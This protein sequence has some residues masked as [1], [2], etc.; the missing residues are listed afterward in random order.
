MRPR[1]KTFLGTLVLILAAAVLAVGLA[2]TLTGDRRATK[3]DHRDQ[4]GYIRDEI[5]NLRK[6]L[7]E[8]TDR[9]REEGKTDAQIE[10]M[11]AKFQ[12]EFD[13]LQGEIDKLTNEKA[14]NGNP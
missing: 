9:A 7:Q 8:E 14:K 6:L 5:K 10:E 13:R 1:V 2:W 11:R 12:A 3:A 4:A